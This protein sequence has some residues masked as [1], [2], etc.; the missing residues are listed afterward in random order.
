MKK[1]LE[2][3]DYLI[4]Q[5]R[6]H[7]STF[8]KGARPLAE[9]FPQYEIGRGSY[10]PLRV[11]S[12]GDEAT[13]KIGAFCSIGPGVSVLLGGEHRMR[14][15]SMYPFDKKYFPPRSGLVRSH[16]SKGDVVIGSDV[17]IGHEALILSG[18]RIGHGAVIGARALVTGEVPPY[19]V[20]VG[21]PARV[22]KYRFSADVI[23]QLLEIAWWDWEDSKIE[24]ARPLFLE[25]DMELFLRFARANQ[26]AAS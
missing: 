8:L 11:H 16:F 12:F 22:V 17:W 7:G 21:S 20:A 14:N 1:I 9:R 2:L 24:Q 3:L 18:A 13:L 26:S 6:V 5:A 19:A 15:V 10:G 23:A 25:D 4:V